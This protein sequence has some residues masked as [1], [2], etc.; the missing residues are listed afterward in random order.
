MEPL[1]PEDKA[2]ILLARPLA[3]PADIEEYERL[4]AERFTKDPSVTPA[5]RPPA[6]LAGPGIRGTVPAKTPDQIREE[7]LL[8]LHKKLFG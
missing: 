6:G 7:R 1:K 2:S 5:L 4:L 8:E 3:Q